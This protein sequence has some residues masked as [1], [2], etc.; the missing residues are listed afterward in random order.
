MN[1]VL[2]KGEVQVSPCRNTD[3]GVYGLTFRVTGESR[4]VGHVYHDGEWRRAVEFEFGGDGVV[5]E[6]HNLAALEVVEHCVAR[7]RTYLE[8]RDV[9]VEMDPEALVESQAVCPHCAGERDNPREDSIE[10]MLVCGHSFHGK[11]T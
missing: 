3:T 2:G 5:I 6:V 8:A 9:P 7:L 10:R 11:N 1:I 4:E